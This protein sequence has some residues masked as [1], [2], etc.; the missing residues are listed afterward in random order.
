MEKSLYNG[1]KKRTGIISV[2][3]SR[4]DEDFIDSMELSPTA[5]LRAKI[6][7]VRENS[8]FYMRRAQD[9]QEAIKQLQNIITKYGTKLKELGVDVETL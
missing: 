6:Q 2:S 3:V 4:A 7:E 8:S 9:L 5:L 1:Q